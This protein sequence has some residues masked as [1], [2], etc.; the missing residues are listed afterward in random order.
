MKA[1]AATQ[2]AGTAHPLPRDA[3]STAS[4]LTAA[5][6]ATRADHWDGTNANEFSGGRPARPRDASTA[7]YVQAGTDTT[8][9]SPSIGRL[10]DVYGGRESRVP[11]SGCSAHTIVRASRTAA[12][13]STPSAS[14][15]HTEAIA[16]ARTT[17][18]NW[19]IAAT[20]ALWPS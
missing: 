20:L 7:A 3:A 1:D 15:D 6:M 19:C 18:A 9:A 2:P 14:P 17:T 5:A 4:R 10:R 8:K 11:R 12:A 16:R 13:P